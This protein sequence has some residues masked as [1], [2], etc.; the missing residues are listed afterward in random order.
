MLSER[1]IGPGSDIS[2]VIHLG[3]A[4]HLSAVMVNFVQAEPSSLCALVMTCNCAMSCV[5][6]GPAEDTGGKGAAGAAHKYRGSTAGGRRPPHLAP[7]G[8][9]QQGARMRATAFLPRVQGWVAMDMRAARLL[10]TE[11][12]WMH[13]S[14]KSLSTKLH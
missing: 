13:D 2:V 14:P 4:P 12:K 8:H 3:R 10:A 11:W 9:R 6:G 5:S 1:L 7:A